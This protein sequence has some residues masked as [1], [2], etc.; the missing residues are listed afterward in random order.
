MYT[1]PEPTFKV[2]GSIY[3]SGTGKYEPIEPYII[4]G[5][6]EVV[7]TRCYICPNGGCLDCPLK[8]TKRRSNENKRD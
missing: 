8:G 7:I 5:N 2:T 4:N 1:I 6:G 3:N